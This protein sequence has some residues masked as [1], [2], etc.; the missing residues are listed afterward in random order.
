MNTRP[1]WILR[2]AS[3]MTPAAWDALICGA[4][5]VVLMLV[6]LAGLTGAI[7]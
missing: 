1:H 3:L 2:L 5:V 7:E 4:A 6:L